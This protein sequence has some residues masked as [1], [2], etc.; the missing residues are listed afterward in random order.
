MST[1]SI[2][3]RPAEESARSWSGVRG[4]ERTVPTTRQPSRRNSSAIAQPRPRDAPTTR[5]RFVSGSV[6]I[7][8]SFAQIGNPERSGTV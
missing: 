2:S 8:V 7:V 5:T 1:V 3:S 4:P 6:A